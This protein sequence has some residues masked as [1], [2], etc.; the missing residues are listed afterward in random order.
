[1]ATSQNIFSETDLLTENC[2][3]SWLTALPCTDV[4]GCPALV[5]C[6]ICSLYRPQI[7]RVV[8]SCTWPRLWCFQPFI[9]AVTVPVETLWGRIGISLTCEIEG[10]TNLYIWISDEDPGIPW[11]VWNEEITFSMLSMMIQSVDWIN[12]LLNNQLRLTCSAGSC[13]TYI[14]LWFD[15]DV[16]FQYRHC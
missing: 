15:V 10:F 5:A 13:E 4:V 9:G 16:M 3:A 8:V 11:T 12:Y 7:Q 2:Y 1:M 14:G 6:F